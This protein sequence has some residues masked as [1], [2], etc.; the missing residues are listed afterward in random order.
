[1]EAVEARI[2]AQRAQ[3]RPDTYALYR[4]GPRLGQRS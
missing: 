4:C 3:D 1:M 2:V